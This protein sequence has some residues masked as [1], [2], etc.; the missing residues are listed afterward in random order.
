MTA[1]QQDPH[2]RC[3]PGGRPSTVTTIAAAFHA[4]SDLPA[5]QVDLAAERLGVG[6]IRVDAD[7]IVSWNDT[8]YRKHGRPR[9]RRV[10]SVEDAI[11][12][13]TQGRKDLQRAYADLCA[14]LDDEGEQVQFDVVGEHGIHHELV[15]RQ[16]AP[17][18]ALVFA[19]PVVPD[20]P[21]TSDTAAT[22]ATS[23]VA[24]EPAAPIASTPSQAPH[25][26][27]SVAVEHPT[28]AASAAVSAEP[29]SAWQE[30]FE[31]SPVSLA[32]VDP[33]GRFHQVNQ[34]FCDLV[35]RT[36]GAVL[37]TAYDALLHPTDRAK[38]ANLAA[39]AGGSDAMQEQRLVRGDGSTVWGR[40]RASE[41]F[42]DGLQ[43]TVIAIEDLTAAKQIEARLREEALQDPLTGLPNRRLLLDRLRRALSRAHRTS[44]QIAVFFVDVDGLKRINDTHGHSAGDE[45]IMLVAACM[46][47]SL[48]ETDTLAR[49]GGDEFVA[50]CEDIGDGQA[51]EEVGQRLLRCVA[52][53]LI[54]GGEAVPVTLSVG[55]AIPQS[56]KDTAEI[57]LGRADAAMYRAKMAGGARLAVSGSLLGASPHEL[58]TAEDWQ[59]AVQSAA[60]HLHYRPVLNLTGELLGFEALLRWDH[61]WLSTLTGNDL[62]D[63]PGSSAVTGEIVRWALRTALADLHEAGGADRFTIWLEVPGRALLQPAT[64]TEISAFYADHTQDNPP[65]LV[66]QVRENELA[67][68][69]RR[70]GAPMPL[71]NLGNI[72]PV[73]LGIVRFRGESVPLA[74]LRQ[75]PLRNI[76]VDSDLLPNLH[77][78]TNLPTDPIVAAIVAAARAVGVDAIATD[79][80]DTDQLAVL[81]D[82]GFIAVQGDFVGE[83]G[84]LESY[85]DLLATG[86][87]HLR[88][89]PDEPADPPIASLLLRPTNR[90]P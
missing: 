23:D 85:A 24:S 63:T 73:S 8:A 20:I 80:S 54:L 74:A 12:A 55:V 34:S 84:P 14:Q 76:T 3:M 46:R 57:L 22:A 37:A 30:L 27:V 4:S 16:V 60:L 50:V 38:G 82:L 41:V 15:L 52:T 79:V 89:R 67:A 47:K 66:L 53:P 1:R 31:N 42:L 39:V 45:L 58:P 11:F 65:A 83:A 78:A 21:A 56:E 33:A 19:P 44:A 18:V 72:G 13:V 51:L 5:R 86:R 68:L 77:P 48:R 88:R 2:H 61:P 25:P 9:W 6:V 75:L 7:G 28:E 71:L 29:N 35:G 26:K 10:R 40:V 32:V 36:R 43:R 70:G 49:I 81:A 87:L 17:G 62:L 64:F 69:L 90:Q 59:V